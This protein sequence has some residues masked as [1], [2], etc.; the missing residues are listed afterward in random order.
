MRVSPDGRRTAVTELDSQLATLDVW[1]YEGAEPVPR[2]ISPAL[3]V[4]EGPVWAPDGARLAWTSARTTV[5]VR[6]AQAMLPEVRLRRFEQ[7][8]RV[9]D[10]SADDRWLVLGLREEGTKDDLWLLDPR[11]AENP[12]AYARSAFSEIN[13]AVSP[14]GR[15]LAYASDE[16]GRFEIY[17]DAFPNASGRRVQLTMGGG[18]EPRWR[19]DARELVFRRGGSLYS[20]AVKPSAGRLTAS[21]TSMLF[22]SSAGLRA[23]DM[24]MDGERFLLNVP[25]AGR[26]APPLHVVVHWY[27][28]A[29]GAVEGAKSEGKAQ[30]R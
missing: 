4:D 22:E 5:M 28:D 19:R 27:A 10:W 2:R 26:E 18:A 20:V 29:L 25:A 14:D 24:T 11:R 16:S 21:N 30:N 7:P 17:A 9:W 12:V 8:A 23:W 1:I 6:G 3:D 15:W 13:A